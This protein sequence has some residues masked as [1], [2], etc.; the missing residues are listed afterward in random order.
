MKKTLALLLCALLT[1]AL[2]PVV[3][4]PASATGATVVYLKDGGTG[5]GSSAENAVGTLTAAFNALDLTQDCTV[6]VCGVFAQTADFNYGSAYTGSVTFT[7]KYGGTDYAASGAVYNAAAKRYYSCGKAIFE[8]ITINLTGGY[9]LVVAQDNPFKIGENVTTTFQNANTKGLGVASALSILAGYQGTNK[10]NAE[11]EKAVTTGNAKVE[12]YSGEKILIVAGNRQLWGTDRTGGTVDI[13]I[14]GTAKIGALYLCSVNFQDLKDGD[15]TVTL[16]DS[17]SIEKVGASLNPDN[18]IKSLTFNWLG[19]TINDS[20]VLTSGSNIAALSNSAPAETVY[21]TYTNGAKLNSNAT[22]QAAANYAEISALFASSAP[23]APAKIELPARPVLTNTTDKSYIAFTAP[24]EPAVTHV[25]NFGAASE[26]L[27]TGGTIV[28]TQKALYSFKSA[29]SANTIDGTKGTVLVTAKDGDTSYINIATDSKET[30][31]I[32]GNNGFAPEN[33]DKTDYL[34]LAGDVILDNVVL[35]NRAHNN[36]GA[37]MATP[38]TVRALAGSKVVI[39]SGV[40]FAHRQ[41]TYTFSGEQVTLDLPNMALDTEEGAVV[42]IDA[43]GF[44]KYTGKGTLVIN[45]DLVSQVSADT[46]AGFEGN[47]VDEEGNAL[48]ATA[49][50][51]GSA[52]VVIAAVALLASFGAIV[53]LKKKEER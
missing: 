36:L 31:I 22:T 44:S 4:I 1:L 8:D 29:A 40:Q 47:V 11:E 3:A 39:G 2:V 7:S 21:T 24:A 53:A 52:T 9:W 49:P 27:T 14:G 18:V 20:M 19:G 28:V 51:T 42:F 16:K 10:A 34:L 37:T 17:A 15:I 23:A 30:G 33:Y 46:F 43:L 26:A 38:N 35:F 32:L 45:K 48:F 6:V 12:V 25:K 41:G 50:A 13:T 5:D